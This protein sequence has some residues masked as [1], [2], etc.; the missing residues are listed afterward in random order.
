M[1]IKN[2]A[3]F[4][5]D[6]NIINV[7]YVTTS[8]EKQYT[9]TIQYFV[10]EHLDLEKGDVNVE[11][12]QTQS[13]LIRVLRGMSLTTDERI[14]IIHDCTRNIPPFTFKFNRPFTEFFME[15][16]GS[17]L[18]QFRNVRFEDT[19]GKDIENNHWDVY[20][21][22]GKNIIDV[23][24]GLEDTFG[25][26]YSYEHYKNVMLNCLNEWTCALYEFDEDGVTL[27]HIDY[28]KK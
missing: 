24:G 13:E 25:N 18:K 8:I 20:H 26:T 27:K 4:E 3:K 19:V 7:N 14:S 12:V 15:S 5:N 2:L 1:K 22:N 17:N 28:P 9:I 6:S 10:I 21:Y 16:V 11:T 23:F